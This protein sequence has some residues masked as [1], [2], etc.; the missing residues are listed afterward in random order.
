MICS[1]YARIYTRLYGPYNI[2]HSL[3]AIDYGPYYVVNSLDS[4]SMISYLKAFPMVCSLLR[5]KIEHS[6]T[7]TQTPMVISFILLL[8]SR[9]KFPDSLRFLS[10]KNLRNFSVQNLNLIFLYGNFHIEN[11]QI[12]KKCFS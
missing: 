2:A 9:S 3:W 5:I 8:I 4:L 7:T 12:E 11:T 6:E 1:L 10:S